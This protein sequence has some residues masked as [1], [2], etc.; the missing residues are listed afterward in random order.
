MN[1]D[2][3]DK[4]NTEVDNVQLEKFKLKKNSSDYSPSNDITKE[5]KIISKDKYNGKVTIE[6]ILKQGSNQVSKEFIVEDFKKKHFDFNTEVDNSFTIKIKDIEK[7]NVLPSAV[8]KEN[9][10][11]EIKDEYKSAIEVQSYE[12][13]EQDNE[14]G[15]LKIK[16]TLKDLIN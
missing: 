5:I 9:I 16:I 13:T 6:V 4:S 12:F 11:I 14:N 8:K 3:E 7:A 1:I 2:Y 10:L 15:K